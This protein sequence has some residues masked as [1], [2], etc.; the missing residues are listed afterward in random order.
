MFCKTGFRR[1][2]VLGH[3]MGRAVIMECQSNIP[4]NTMKRIV[5]RVRSL[6][7]RA[8]E[9]T[10]AAG[11]LPDRVTELRQAMT[12]T[13]GELKN[14]KSGIEVNMTDLQT[15]REDELGEAL[16]E[17]AAHAPV[18]AEAGFILD[19]L[20]V[21]VCPEQ[22]VIV[23]LVRHDDIETLEIQALIQKYQQQK[24]VRAILSAIL[25]ARAMVE[26]IEIDGLDYHKLTVGI[27]RVPTIRLCW[28]DTSTDASVSAGG[29]M[30]AENTA[31][32]PQSNRKNTAFPQES[33][34]GAPPAL[35]QSAVSA[36]AAATAT[37]GGEIQAG[38]A[39][40]SA[41]EPATFAPQ[42]K[43]PVESAGRQAA[44]PPPLPAKGG[45]EPAPSPPPL[46]AE[47]PPDPLAKF[48][49]MPNLKR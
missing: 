33:F 14:L 7:E 1:E 12:A 30:F 11:Q 34:F 26:T 15:S 16:A 47:D 49:K 44:S 6:N 29:D 28:R 4:N 19:G 5:R 40:E 39:A 45:P 3:A 35:T 22:R 9:L 48:R 27:G 21:E 23:Q 25:K 2:F 17:V 43:T 8:A 31:S 46:P 32:G 37:N 24:A 20:D 18:L 42:Q 41:P 10:A 36:D 38:S 13:S